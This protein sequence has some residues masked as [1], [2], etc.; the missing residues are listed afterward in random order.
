MFCWYR[1][2]CH[3]TGSDLL[4][5]LFTVFRLSPLYDLVSDDYPFLPWIS[6]WFWYQFWLDILWCVMTILCYM[7]QLMYF[8]ITRTVSS[9]ISEF[10][11]CISKCEWISSSSACGIYK[12]KGRDL[13]QSY[14]KNP[15][16]NRKI[17][18]Q[19]DNTKKATKNFDYTTIADRFWTVSWSNNSHPTCVC[20]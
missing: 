10:L 8:E 14:D 18:K 17:Q 13:I 11:L 20:G 6:V 9:T 12:R 19:H 16:T 3:R 15:Y 7:S 5:F 1:G 4:L 2:F